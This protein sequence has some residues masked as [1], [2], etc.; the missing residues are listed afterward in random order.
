MNSTPPYYTTGGSVFSVSNSMNAGENCKTN[1]CN[2]I[3]AGGIP[4]IPHITEM[5]GSNK[6]N[7][8]NANTTCR[9]PKFR[10]SHEFWIYRT[11]V[12]NKHRG[13][14]EYSNYGH[15]VMIPGTVFILAK[16]LIFAQNPK[17]LQPIGVNIFYLKL[18]IWQNSKFEILK[19]RDKR[20][21]KLEFKAS[22]QFLVFS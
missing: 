16:K 12:I 2:R 17:F 18:L 10:T 1:I 20:F 9:L 8:Q 22:N 11:R 5:K 15:I 4:H 6:H 14:F 19:F 7:L 21:R 13:S 3:K